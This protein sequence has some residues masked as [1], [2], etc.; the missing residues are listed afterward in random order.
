MTSVSSVTT[1]AEK[2]TIEGFKVA[3][4]TPDAA[5]TPATATALVGIYGN[6][7][8]STASAK[9]VKDL[10]DYA[11]TIANTDPILSSNIMATVT[12]INL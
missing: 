12:R 3:L 2:A 7:P 9:A 11:N 6:G 1:K 4:S 10:T 5:L 8:S